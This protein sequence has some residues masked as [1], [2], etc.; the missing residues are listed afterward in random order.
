MIA[1]LP[2]KEQKEIFQARFALIDM[3]NKYSGRRGEI[4]GAVRGILCAL[5]DGRND[6]LRKIPMRAEQ[7]QD[8]RLG[9]CRRRV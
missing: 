3:A 8:V 5:C 9:L 6:I 1:E 7:T 2:P 4:L